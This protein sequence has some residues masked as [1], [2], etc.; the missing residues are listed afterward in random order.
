M[1]LITLY[2]LTL[3]DNS[4][5]PNQPKRKV[6]LMSAL[7][8]FNLVVISA[9]IVF[10]IIKGKPSNVLSQAFPANI[11]INPT[12]QSL[13]PDVAVSI[14]L[15]SNT[16]SIAFAR[17]VILF[18]QTKVNLSSEVTVSGT[19]ANVLEKS[20]AEQANDSG[21][22][23]VAVGVAPGTPALNGVITDFIT[24]SLTAVSSSPDDV[25]QLTLDTPNM[26]LV[27]TQTLTQVPI[28]GSTATYTLNPTAP[29]S[30]PIPS[31][32]DTPTP[33]PI[34]TPTA[35]PTPIPTPTPTPISDT[36]PPT[37]NVTNPTNG[38]IVTRSTNVTIQATASDN[39]GV[40]KVEFYVN[41]KRRC[42]DMV[43]EYECPWLVPTT[44]NTLYTI[45]AK[46]FD[47]QNN[48]SINQITVTSSN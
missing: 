34:P 37:V 30:T 17:V 26:Q 43:A 45:Q 8:L 38:A 20:T 3:M 9:L 15:D 36:E 28:S 19:F 7:V 47:A 32:T 48:T 14:A 41:G 23:V 21:Q 25:V 40:T 33:T 46:A 31:P 16:N 27:E 22:I 5:N 10:V 18:D 44:P 6:F 42:T 39:V 4:T 13:P 11:T 35:T 29:T 2:G 12:Q 24:F 1:A